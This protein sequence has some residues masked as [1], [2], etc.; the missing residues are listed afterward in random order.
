[1]YQVLDDALTLGGGDDADIRIRGVGLSDVHLRLVRDGDAFVL[2]CV[3][4]GAAFRFDGAEHRKVRLEHGDKVELDH[5]Q[6]TFFCDV[7]PPPR[8]RRETVQRVRAAR[9]RRSGMPAWALA[10]CVIVSL[11]AVGAYLVAESGGGGAASGES[12]LELAR[13]QWERK[14]AGAALA[15][16][17]LARD[18]SAPSDWPA[19]D[20][21]EVRI[22]ATLQERV[23]RVVVQNGRT[24]VRSMRNVEQR[25]LIPDPNHRA[26]ARELMRQIDSW[27]RMYGADAGRIDAL[28]QARAEVRELAGRYREVAAMHESDTA[29]DVLFAARWRMRLK[30]KRLLEA[31]EMIE[32]WLAKNGDHA[33][34]RACRDECIRE[35]EKRVEAVLRGVRTLVARRD[36]HGARSQLEQVAPLA[37]RFGH[38][39]EVD[40]LE[41]ELGEN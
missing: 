21:L 12:Y 32:A 8:P 31:V 14:D 40:R 16:L 33:E 18:R 29:Q 34:V 20:A 25:Y 11:V 17:E 28:G 6:L 37:R 35:S 15:S 26:A 2:E 1:M 22:R 13:Q 39:A 24:D 10:S 27:E 36:L 4:D 9:A 41:A 23:D 30:P 7:P 5:T 3:G 19:I 38:G